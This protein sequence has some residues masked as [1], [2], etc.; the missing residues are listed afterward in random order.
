MLWKTDLPS[1]DGEALSKICDLRT[2]ANYH[3]STWA[4]AET[5]PEWFAAY[6]IP[7]HEKHVS[8]LLAEKQI[9]TFLPLYRMARQWKKSCPIVLELPLFPTYVFVHIHRRER[10]GV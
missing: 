7:R 6:T 1:K 9:E 8:E 2:C 4:A 3:E 5:S 10:G